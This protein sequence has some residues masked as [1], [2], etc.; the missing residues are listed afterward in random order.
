VAS[1]SRAVWFEIPDCVLAEYKIGLLF[2]ALVCLLCH[3]AVVNAHGHFCCQLVGDVAVF[4]FFCISSLFFLVGCSEFSLFCIV[5]LSV[6]AYSGEKRYIKTQFKKKFFF[7]PWLNMMPC[8]QQ[9]A[10]IFFLYYRLNNL[11]SPPIDPRLRKTF[12]YNTLL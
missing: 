1:Y 5:C 9:H 2:F 12:F 3:H 4:L 11:H 8:I 6:T 10:A 7:L